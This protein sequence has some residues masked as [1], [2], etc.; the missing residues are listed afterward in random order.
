MQQ[1]KVKKCDFVCED[2][3]DD[4]DLDLDILNDDEE[5]FT[6]GLMVF[7]VC[8]TYFLRQMICGFSS[9]AHVCFYAFNQVNR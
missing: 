6:L 3:V 9:Q 5:V 8:L 1:L 4:M 2:S 7:H